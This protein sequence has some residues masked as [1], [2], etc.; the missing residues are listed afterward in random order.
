MNRTVRQSGVAVLGVFMADVVFRVDRPPRAGE[1]IRCVSSRL[2]PGG[3]GSNQAI[4]VARLGAKARLVTRIG[5]DAFGE[6]ARR[7]WADAGVLCDGVVIDDTLPSGVA[8]ITVDASSGENSIV[9]DP[10]AGDT[11]SPADVARAAPQI[12]SSA[13]LLTQLEQPLD[14]A[15]EALRAA[16]AGGVFT[17]LNPAPFHPVEPAIMMLC[18]L[19]IPN[20]VEASALVGRP[21]DTVAD[22][23]RAGRDIMGQGA[24]AALV[25]LGEQGAVYVDGDVA[26]HVPALEGVVPV[27]TT[28][29]GD[30]FCAGLAVGLAEGMGVAGA[31]ALASTAAGLCVTM[32][33]AASAMPLRAQCDEILADA[34]RAPRAVVLQP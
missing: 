2:G 33:G 9:I 30:A 20:Q 25:T 31:M 34:G 24:R 15:R 19:V 18:D 11:L 14:A 3:K 27:D 23:L 26:L 28:G 6:L 16:R 12:L 21:V 5:Q 22:A 32:Q 17:I 1:T 29:A 10:G 8:G 4:G 13:V 7:T